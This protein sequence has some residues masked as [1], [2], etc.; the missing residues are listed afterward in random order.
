MITPR[1]SV[2]QD[3]AIVYVTIHAPHVRAQTIEFDVDDDQF[4]FFASPYYLRLTF[5]GKIVEDQAS[6]AS[7]D[8]ATGDIAVTLSKQT[9]GEEFANLDLLTSL[10][11][12]RRERDASEQPGRPVIEEMTDGD[13]VEAALQQ[14]YVDEDFDWEIPQT[15]AAAGDEPV[16]AGSATYGFDQ[17]YSGY[18]AHVHGTANEINEVADP[19]RMTAE[20]RRRSRIACEDAKFDEDYYMDNYINDEDIRPLVQHQ[21]QAQQALRQQRAHQQDSAVDQLAEQLDQTLPAD[22]SDFTDAEKQTMLDLPRKTHIISNKQAVYLGLVDILFAYALD[23][24]INLDEPSVESAWSI[25][26][27]SSSL[28]NLEQFATLRSVVVAC[29]RRALAYPLYRN[30]ELCERALEDVSAMCKLGRRALLKAMLG[31]KRLFD[32]HDVYYVYSKLYLDD[33]CVWLQTAAS[34]KVIRSLARKLHHFELD[35]DEIGWNL[36]AYEDLA[37]MTSESD[38]GESECGGEPE[39]HAFSDTTEPDPKPLI[40]VIGDPGTSAAPDSNAQ[41]SAH[42]ATDLESASL[43]PALPDLLALEQADPTS[44]PRTQSKKKPLIEIIE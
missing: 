18:L 26:A 15:L 41:N 37:L 39:Q 44:Q 6:T 3:D 21:S 20:E 35:K 13:G 8:A 34:D 38:A 25:G 9:P 19:E 43:T 36:D 33:Y 2:R 1:F 17:Q 32:K 7:F 16:L 42:A 27:V 24:R 31:L 28:S 14:A 10:L 11:A 23:L 4:K 40:Q 30:W 22:N 12:T 5:P 29:F